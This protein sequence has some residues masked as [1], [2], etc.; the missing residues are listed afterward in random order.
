MQKGRD[1]C[2]KT[3]QPPIFASLCVNSSLYPPAVFP[4]W[5]A[6]RT[7]LLKASASPHS[8]EINH[9]FCLVLVSPL[10]CFSFPAERFEHGITDSSFKCVKL[11]LV[12]VTI[13]AETWSVHNTCTGEKCCLGTR[14][15][16]LCYASSHNSGNR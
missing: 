8:A 12:R 11:L 15:E 1:F 3:P 6:L 7:V 10:L 13:L 2:K 5:A 14:G 9:T 16:V 4:G